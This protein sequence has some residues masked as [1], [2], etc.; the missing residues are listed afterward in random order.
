MVVIPAQI[1]DATGYVAA[2]GACVSFYNAGSALRVLYK[3][4]TDEPQKA[5]YMQTGFQSCISNSMFKSSF[6]FRQLFEATTYAL[7]GLALS[8]LT[9]LTLDSKKK[10]STTQYLHQQFA[11]E[12]GPALKWSDVADKIPD[13]VKNSIPEPAEVVEALGNFA[14]NTLNSVGE[15]VAPMFKPPEKKPVGALAKT[16]QSIGNAFQKIVSHPFESL[17]ATAIGGLLGNSFRLNLMLQQ[18][19][20]IS[21]KNT[22]QLAKQGDTLQQILGM[23]TSSRRFSPFV[24][25]E[26][27]DADPVPRSG[28]QASSGSF[29]VLGSPAQESPQP[30]GSSG[31]G[32]TY[33]QVDASSNPD[34][35]PNQQLVQTTGDT[36]SNGGLFSGWFS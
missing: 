19:N 4:Q 14:A 7:T 1:N 25:V 30:Q 31:L 18:L 20:I 11:V 26:G 12:R 5:S 8:A 17:I 34:G 28:S 2:A 10:Y 23:F 32:G 24:P 35:S 6:V 29:V 33:V 16:Q 22:E 21:A 27:S 3:G 15:L 13:S 36:T 9:A